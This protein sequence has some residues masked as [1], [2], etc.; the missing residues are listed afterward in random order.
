MYGFTP[1]DGVEGATGGSELESNPVKGGYEKYE[2]SFTY[3]EF[4]AGSPESMLNYSSGTNDTDMPSYASLQ[5]V[6]HNHSYPL[7]SGQEPRESSSV[8][9]EI[10]NKKTKLTFTRDVRKAK[11]MKIPITVD[12]IVHLPVEE[13]NQL[14]QKYSLTESQLQLIRDIRR[15]GKNKVA[16]QNCRKRKI[17]VIDTLDTQVLNLR[18]QKNSL[19]KERQKI[20]KEL[21]DLK[22]KFG[23]LYDEVF[24]SLRDESGR[25]YS[26]DEYSLQHM[27]DGNVILVPKNNTATKDHQ[28]K[29]RKKRRHPRDD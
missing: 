20:H 26:P 22:N 8:K 10:E 2:P 13:F 11:E 4:D 21:K 15:R 17:E 6:Q 19:I 16:A 27:P 9:K 25:P 5:Q 12:D 18:K 7:Q 24:R 29:T 23:H 28:E 14:L 3:G 1:L